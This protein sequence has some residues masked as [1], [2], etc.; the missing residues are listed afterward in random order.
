WARTYAFY[1]YFGVDGTLL[2]FSTRDYVLRSIQ[3]IFPS[4]VVTL[5]LAL[6]LLGLHRW[7][8]RLDAGS[9]RRGVD[10]ASRVLIAAGILLTAFGLLG[11]STRLDS[12]CL[13]S[14]C[15][16]KNPYATPLAIVLGPVA[17]SYGLYL[18]K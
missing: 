10:L 18:P 12:V 17:L 5:L 13:G 1:S 16:F 11:L 14:I 9:H 3:P 15:P 2:G 4:L 6:C 8:H 7:L